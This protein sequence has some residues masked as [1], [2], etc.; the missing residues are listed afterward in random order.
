MGIRESR[1]ERSFP[2]MCIP[3]LA[4]RSIFRV[5][6]DL[7]G[8]GVACLS[9]RMSRRV[10]VSVLIFGA[11]LAGLLWPCRT[12]AVPKPHVISFGK[13][14]TVKWAIGSSGS[15]EKSVDLKI[16]PLYVDTR[17]KEYTTGVP[18]EVTDRLF[19]VRRVFRV[20]DALPDEGGATP[21]WE[22]QRGGWLLVDRGT[23]RVTQISLPEF[24]AFYS[25][26]SWY[27]DYVAYCGVTDDGQK[28]FA[29][30]AQLG[31]RKP[32][33]KKTLGERGAEDAPDSECP[34]PRWERR[35]AR[36]TFEPAEKQR[37]TF[38]V[39]GHVVDLVNDD[40]ESEGSE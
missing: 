12:L 5:A 10:S 13:W 19:V 24:D 32:I 7:V 40:E 20:N 29:M 28:L 33:L 8:D 17:L 39:R 14:T 4:L 37:L 15:E 3:H 34:A 23:G 36:V 35:P 21:R 6:T 26:A 38:T 31:R 2:E 1:E 9:E 22:W 11:C 16:R 25:T 18:H 27:R 30:V